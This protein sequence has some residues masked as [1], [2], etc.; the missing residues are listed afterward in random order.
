MRKV[1]EAQGVEPRVTLSIGISTYP[2]DCS[3]HTELLRLA[4][5]ACYDAKQ[6][7]GN[8]VNFVTGQM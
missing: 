6:Q 2:T 5:R 3:S 7:G 1:I 4:D 8:R